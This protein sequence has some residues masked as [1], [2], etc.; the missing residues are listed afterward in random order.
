MLEVSDLDIAINAPDRISTEQAHSL[1]ERL[2]GLQTK[3]DI[4]V[5]TP[6]C[7]FSLQKFACTVVTSRPLASSNPT[8]PVGPPRQ[9]EAPPPLDDFS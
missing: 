4:R 1:L 7:G 8:L 2:K 5:E 3:A 9:S 6:E